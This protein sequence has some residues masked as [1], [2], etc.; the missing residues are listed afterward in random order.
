MD[1]HTWWKSQN[2]GGLRPLPITYEWA[3]MAWEAATEH[4]RQE[5]AM[6]AEGFEDD[7]GYGK[8]QM[9]ADAIRVRSNA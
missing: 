7:M 9:I 6:V 8:A 3:R 5:C 4:E 2:S 1:F